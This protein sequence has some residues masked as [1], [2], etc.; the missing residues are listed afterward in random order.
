MDL[1]NP[2]TDNLY[3]FFAISGLIIIIFCL[4]VP[5]WYLKEAQSRIMELQTEIDILKIELRY[6]E[7]EVKAETGNKTLENLT[8]AELK[9]E[10]REKYKQWDIKDATI[11]G[12]IENEKWLV[13]FIEGLLLFTVVGVG[14]GIYIMRHRFLFWYDRLQIF[15]DVIIENEALKYKLQDKIDSKDNPN[16]T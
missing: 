12:K 15:Q 3:K 1:P 6:L 13:H 7:I 2:P 11:R 5:V 16:K 14:I 8:L 4:V 10:T 9:P